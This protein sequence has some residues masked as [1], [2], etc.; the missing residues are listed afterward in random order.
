MWRKT[1]HETQRLGDSA[2]KS[3]LVVAPP[4]KTC[5]LELAAPDATNEGEDEDGS[6][7]NTNRDCAESTGVLS[8]FGARVL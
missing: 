2:D 4:L 5:A 3:Q 6:D 8:F 1:G 7:F